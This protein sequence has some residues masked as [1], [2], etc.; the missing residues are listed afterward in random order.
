MLAGRIFLA[1]YGLFEVG[2]IRFLFYESN[3]YPNKIAKKA[4]KITMVNKL[5]VLLFFSLFA[6]KL[7]FTT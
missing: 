2:K 6:N 3:Q 5:I 4:M 7:L 1:L